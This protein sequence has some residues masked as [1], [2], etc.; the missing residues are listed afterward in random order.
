MVVRVSR[1]GGPPTTAARAASCGLR[2]LRNAHPMGR[3]TAQ[4]APT[5]SE[6]RLSGSMAMRPVTMR[7]NAT[8][9]Q[10]HTVPP[11]AGNED[12]GSRRPATTARR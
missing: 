2:A 7:R 12:A 9:I 3:H 6:M 5:Y 8:A 1:A 4:P 10:L 11:G